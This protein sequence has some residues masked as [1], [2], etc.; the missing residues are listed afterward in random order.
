MKYSI[1]RKSKYSTYVPIHLSKSFNVNHSKRSSFA[2][3]RLA[4]LRFFR[5]S[6][7]LNYA[8]STYIHLIRS[9]RIRINYCIAA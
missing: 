6:Y 8:V 2:Y 7:Q 1:R 5:C 4:I 3:S 9:N